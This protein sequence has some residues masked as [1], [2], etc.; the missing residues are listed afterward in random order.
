LVQVRHT[1]GV[2]GLLTFAYDLQPYFAFRSWAIEFDDKD[3]LPRPPNE[4]PIDDRKHSGM[5]EKCR[6]QM[7]VGVIVNSVVAI[8]P[9]PW[10]YILDLGEHVLHKAAFMFVCDYSGSCMR[11]TDDAR[12]IPYFTFF[13]KIH[14]LRRDIDELPSFRRPQC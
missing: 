7:S 12:S 5:P 6:G 11:H 8:A 1:R 4:L 14:H 9:R 13:N 10:E 2:Y 3:V